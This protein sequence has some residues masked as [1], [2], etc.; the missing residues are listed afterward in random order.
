MSF[1]LSKSSSLLDDD[2]L[3][4]SDNNNYEIFTLPTARNPEDKYPLNVNYNANFT[5]DEVLFTATMTF[6]LPPSPEMV[7][8]LLNPDGS[9]QYYQKAIK[10][11]NIKTIKQKRV[12][13][14]PKKVQSNIIFNG[15]SISMELDVTTPI[16]TIIKDLCFPAFSLPYMEGYTLFVKQ[17]DSFMRP[18]DYKKLLIEDTQTFDT[19]YFKR[20]YFV[21]SR[22][23]L[24]DDAIT[25]QVFKDC[26]D[27]IMSNKYLPIARENVIVL[28][29]YQLLAERKVSIEDIKAGNFDFNSMI[30]PALP[31]KDAQNLLKYFITY[32]SKLTPITWQ[33][34]AIKYIKNA[35]KLTGF[36][37]IRFP[38]SVSNS[39]VG[40]FSNVTIEIG[41]ILIRLFDPSNQIIISPITYPTI[42]SISS[43]N[44]I[45]TLK[46]L[47]RESHKYVTIDFTARQL[48]M[49]LS[50]LIVNYINITKQLMDKQRQSSSVTED[51]CLR[52][53]EDYTVEYR[54]A[55][56][57][58]NDSYLSF[59]DESKEV[60]TFNKVISYYCK[61]SSIQASVKR[62][63]DLVREFQRI[64]SSNPDAYRYELPQDK[65]LSKIK[66]IF[67]A[68]DR[69]AHD[70]HE[71][72]H[73]REEQTQNLKGYYQMICER[74][75]NGVNAL[76]GH[77]KVS[78]DKGQVEDQFNSANK[79]HDELKFYENE[80]E[81]IKSIYSRFG[82]FEKMKVS[83]KPDDLEKKVS[84]LLSDVVDVK[85]TLLARFGRR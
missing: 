40:S 80:I 43:K 18:L 84:S 22:Q 24:S 50:S 35:R 28:T 16:Q 47:N 7:A 4:Q 9:T 45:L 67:D 83:P 30:P 37:A 31:Q 13:L 51:P 61:R 10:I 52:V 58:L 3:Q 44:D 33:E 77:W 8:M 76:E 26:R 59:T 29:Y 73:F 62:L 1:E 69:A 46:Y 32:V 36:G 2:L 74:V 81:Y 78:K 57:S 23:E 55:L 64:H 71:K 21:I 79:A 65:P 12:V 66:E 56:S 41:P 27:E 70:A 68:C 85:T 72:M 15:I 5:L 53:V 17:S 6:G 63:E 48:G 60:S 54:R 25:E 49:T 42:S 38:G 82:F 75:A 11:K 39:E 19:F 20:C 34:A 14:F